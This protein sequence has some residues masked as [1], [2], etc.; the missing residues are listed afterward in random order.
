M[1]Y[2]ASELGVM[3]LLRN[4]DG[5]NPIRAIT[6]DIKYIWNVMIT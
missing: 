6:L 2:E 1:V 3:I 4:R 5:N